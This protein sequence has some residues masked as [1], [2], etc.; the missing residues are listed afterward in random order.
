MTGLFAGALLA[1]S[2]AGI[3]AASAQGLP[4]AS[5]G[6]PS[7]EE[8]LTEFPDLYPGYAFVD[9]EVQHRP[10]KRQPKKER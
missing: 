4:E 8:V 6:K 3:A 9:S 2:I 1:G 10:S 5:R 7:I